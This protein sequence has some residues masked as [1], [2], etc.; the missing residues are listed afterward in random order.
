MNNRELG[1]GHVPATLVDA[2]GNARHVVLKPSL[3]A[4]RTLSRKY[5]GLS[6]V[7]DR[8]LKADF[9]VLV[10][11]FEVGMQVPT[12][13]PKTRRELEESVYAAGILD[14]NG[15]LVLVASN[16]LN[17][18]VHGGRLPP[19]GPEEVPPANPQIAS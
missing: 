16:F 9:D 17:V 7:A 10:D 2:D 5:G 13:N 1:A 15:G 3:H 18:L 12:G 6:A 19:A 14:G 8:V 11:V 4:V